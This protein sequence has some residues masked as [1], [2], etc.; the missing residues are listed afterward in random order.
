MINTYCRLGTITGLQSA[1]LAMN[2]EPTR[3]R[4][5]RVEPKSLVQYRS[6]MCDFQTLQLVL[7]LMA[8]NLLRRAI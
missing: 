4:I 3:A 1:M 6:D 2:A 8:A 7:A 5:S